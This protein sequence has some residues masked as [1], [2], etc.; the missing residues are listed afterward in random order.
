MLQSLLGPHSSF[1]DKGNYGLPNSCRKDHNFLLAFTRPFFAA[2]VRCVSNDIRFAFPCSGN[3]VLVGSLG[4][5]LESLASFALFLA[6]YEVQ[7]VDFSKE[8]V[9]IDGMKSLFRQAGLEGKPIGVII[10]VT[11]MGVN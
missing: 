1:G 8:G 5:Q 4:Q 10:K 9:F 6:G 2:H 3:S 11:Y 7:T